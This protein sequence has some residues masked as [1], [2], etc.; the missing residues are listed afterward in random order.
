VGLWSRPADEAPWTK[1]RLGQ[2]GPGSDEN[3]WSQI[4]NSVPGVGAGGIRRD[5]TVAAGHVRALPAQRRVAGE[6]SLVE[7][8]AGSLATCL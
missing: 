8:A 4:A 7:V 1:N 6:G 3:Q 2:V 5:P